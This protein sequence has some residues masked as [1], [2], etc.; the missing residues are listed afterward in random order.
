M[1]IT[2]PICGLRNEAEFSYLGD[3]SLR[4]PDDSETDPQAWID[5]VYLRKNPRG[6]HQEYWHHLQGCR[7]WL[8]LERNTLTHEIGACKLARDV[9]PGAATKTEAAE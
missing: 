2:C 5:Y 4:R 6:W 3:A 1:R 7:E 9:E 8:V